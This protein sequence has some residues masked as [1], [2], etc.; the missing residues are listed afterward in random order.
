MLSPN[1]HKPNFSEKLDPVFAH[2][3]RM[4]LFCTEQMLYQ[5]LHICSQGF[6]KNMK[7]S[8]FV[9]RLPWLSCWCYNFQMFL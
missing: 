7:K 8:P 4:G 1:K 5:Y 3:T 2:G 6:K 9:V